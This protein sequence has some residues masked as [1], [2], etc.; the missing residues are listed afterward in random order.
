MWVFGPHYNGSRPKQM[1]HK[2]RQTT[3]KVNKRQTQNEGY[4]TG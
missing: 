2:V 3:Y 4:R 1:I